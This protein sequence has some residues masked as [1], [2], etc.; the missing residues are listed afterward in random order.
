MTRIRSRR[1]VA[2][3]ALL[4]AMATGACSRDVLVGENQLAAGSAHPPGSAGGASGTDGPPP[5]CQV[6]HCQNHLYA[7][8]DCKD[9]DGDGL[10]DMDDPDCLGPCQNSESMFF[11]GIP[12]QNNAGCVQAC[13]FDQDSGSANDDCLWSHKCDPRSVAPDFPPE[14]AACAYDPNTVVPRHGRAGDCA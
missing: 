14:G 3:I 11:G 7:C 4:V 13:Y 9:N 8:G 12:G 1:P 10:I 6:V 2:R 5:T